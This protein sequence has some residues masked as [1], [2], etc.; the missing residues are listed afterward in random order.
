MII[1]HNFNCYAINRKLPSIMKIKTPEKIKTIKVPRTVDI[2]AHE[3]SELMKTRD[4][5]SPSHIDVLLIDINEEHLKNDVSDLL[6]IAFLEDNTEPPRWP[7][8]GSVYGRYFRLM[9]PISVKHKNRDKIIFFLLDTGSPFTFLSPTSLESLGFK[10]TFP[11]SVQMEVHGQ[12]MTVY[13]SPQDKHFK[14]INILGADFLRIMK[15]LLHVDF[16]N[17]NL[18]ISL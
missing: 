10:D 9:V 6:G 11:E 1:S 4:D 18:E 7:I 3:S 13:P 12:K 16:N 8:K 2:C 15:C 17:L 14:D 5:I